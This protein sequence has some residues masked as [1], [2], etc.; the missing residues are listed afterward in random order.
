MKPL[1]PTA[2]H[3]IVA[4]CKSG[5]L[6]TAMAVLCRRIGFKAGTSVL[7]SVFTSSAISGGP[8]DTDWMNVGTVAKEALHRAGTSITPA[9]RKAIIAAVHAPGDDGGKIAEGYGD[10]P[11]PAHIDKDLAKTLA[12]FDAL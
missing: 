7:R 5:N 2:Q 11:W 8:W 6:A 4:H 1:S 9:T 3:A 12:A 10:D